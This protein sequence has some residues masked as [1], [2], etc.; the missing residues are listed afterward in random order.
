MFPSLSK[1]DR[2][3]FPL[4]SYDNNVYLMDETESDR[5]GVDIP[6]WEEYRRIAAEHTDKEPIF[7]ERFEFYEQS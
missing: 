5:G 2:E 7:L 4:D 1:P 6:I 3:L